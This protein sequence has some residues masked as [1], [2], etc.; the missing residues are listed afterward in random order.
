MRIY[1]VQHG[2][3]K[4]EDVD[5]GRHLTQKG[6]DD[7]MKMS[8]F[9]KN[10]G[11]HVDAIWHS[12][13]TRAAQTADI[14]A[15]GIAADQGIIQHDGLAPNDDIGLIKDELLQSNLDLMIVGHLPFLSK[16]AS[17]LV[18][19]DESAGTVTFQQG[20]V[21]CLEQDQAKL[22]TVRWMVVP[23]LLSTEQFR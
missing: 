14:L 1:L 5:P 23:E 7:A 21:V 8:A 4:S 11:L 18:I 15:A 3:A 6:I 22:W 19:G 2:Q 16:L 12:G 13:K 10:A 9:L 20:G 17:S